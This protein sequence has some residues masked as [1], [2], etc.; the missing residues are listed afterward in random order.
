MLLWQACIARAFYELAHKAVFEREAIPVLFVDG[1]HVAGCIVIKRDGMLAREWNAGALPKRQVRRIRV[2]G[3]AGIGGT[4]FGNAVEE[5]FNKV[6]L[7]R[8]ILNA[9]AIAHRWHETDGSCADVEGGACRCR[10]EREAHVLSA[11]HIARKGK[12]DAFEIVWEGLD[13]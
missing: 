8:Y 6:L 4:G 12:I 1:K 11:A 5:S 9:N 2:A 7:A 10:V 13:T 3:P